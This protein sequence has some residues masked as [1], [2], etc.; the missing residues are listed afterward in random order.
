LFI[1]YTPGG[2]INI[3]ALLKIASSDFSKKN[4][5]ELNFQKKYA[6]ISLSQPFA[7]NLLVF[8]FFIFSMSLYLYIFGGVFIVSILSIISV[9]FLALSPQFL[10]KIT[11]FLVSLSAGTLLGDSFLHLL[12]EAVANQPGSLNVW[13]WLM[14]GVILF[15]VLEKIVHWRHCHI[16]TCPDHPHHLG[17][18]NLVGDC[19]HNFFDGLIIAGSF[20]VSVPLGIATLVAVIAH[21]IPQEIGDFGVLIYAG[22]SRMRALWLNFLTALSS[23]LGA[24]L[25]ILF[26]SW[27]ANFSD[28]IIPLTAGGFIY[29][30]TADLI[31]ELKKETKLSKTVYQLITIVLGVAIMWLLKLLFE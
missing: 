26:G 14:T 9:F 10:K 12:P 24:A 18:M 6:I 11:L 22:Y 8:P 25:I 5:F 7:G 17:I 20:L 27:I 3:I 19:F 2:G 15:F 1:T 23:F 28:I 16:Q 4:F 30:A 21:E 31:P 29:I 13:L